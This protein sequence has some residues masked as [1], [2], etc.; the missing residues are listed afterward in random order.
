MLERQAQ[1][2]MLTYLEKLHGAQSQSAT[3]P[4]LQKGNRKPLTLDGT[5]NHP[6]K[7]FQRKLVDKINNSPHQLTQRQ[8][9]KKLFGLPM[10]Q[11]MES[12]NHVK[13]KKKLSSSVI[14]REWIK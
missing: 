9:L 7:L 4:S 14:Q 1:T 3:N 8:K 12:P 13:P 10:V 6:K 2:D 11:R 5:D